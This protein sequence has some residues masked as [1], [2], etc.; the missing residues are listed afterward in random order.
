MDKIRHTVITSSRVLNEL[1]RID[2]HHLEIL[3]PKFCK[4]PSGKDKPRYVLGNI[5]RSVISSNFC[6]KKKSRA[7]FEHCCLLTAPPTPGWRDWVW[8]RIEVLSPVHNQE[9]LCLSRHPQ[10]LQPTN[11]VIAADLKC[12]NYKIKATLLVWI[13]LAFRA[14]SDS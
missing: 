3:I 7:N 14:S 5:D 13:N 4:N 6:G 10:N 1:N 11:L 9:E 12:S 2:R 8:E